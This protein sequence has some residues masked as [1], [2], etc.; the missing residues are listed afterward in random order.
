[1]Y[2]YVCIY[3]VYICIYIHVHVV[4]LFNF[5]SR[6]KVFFFFFCSAQNLLVEVHFNFPMECSGMVLYKGYK[7]I[8]ECP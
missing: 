2:A 5:F 7:N 3:C 4:T 6:I 8:C 1:M